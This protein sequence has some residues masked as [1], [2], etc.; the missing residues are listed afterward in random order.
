MIRFVLCGG[1]PGRARSPLSAG[2]GEGWVGGAKTLRWRWEEPN[3]EGSTEDVEPPV[4]WL[5]DR[6]CLTG[7]AGSVFLATRQDRHTPYHVTLPSCALLFGELCHIEKVSV[8]LCL[9]CP[10][11]PPTHTDCYLSL[12]SQHWAQSLCQVQVHKADVDP[13]SPPVH[14]LRQPPPT[15]HILHAPLSPLV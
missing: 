12:Y 11:P 3:S 9:P 1:W 14:D 10:P 2:T 4:W 8:S 13:A 7:E 5:S 15:F 6:H